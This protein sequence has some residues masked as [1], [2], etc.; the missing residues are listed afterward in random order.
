MFIIHLLLFPCMCLTHVIMHFGIPKE[1]I[2]NHGK[3][4][5]N[6][7]FQKL[8]QLNGFTH[9][10][11]SPYYP[12]SNGQVEVV[13]EVVK[14]ML[15]HTVNKHKTNWCHMIYFSLWACCTL[16]KMSTRFTPFHLVYM[17]E[18][19][20]LIKCEIPTIRTPIKILLDT[21]SLEQRLIQLEHVEIFW[22]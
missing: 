4:F 10:F 6:E 11:Y 7:V 17:L 21:S 14:T 22:Q 20:L 5:K 12:Q 1:L 8:S 18:A 9:E 13:N 2:S 15:K 3:H 16:I 19:V